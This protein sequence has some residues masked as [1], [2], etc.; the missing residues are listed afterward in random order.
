MLTK[1][2]RSACAKYDFK[3][4]TQY[5]F[6]CK[7]EQKIHTSYTLLQLCKNVHAFEKKH[8]KF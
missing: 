3:T 8:I 6:V 1:C 2:T 5:N 4:V 7:C